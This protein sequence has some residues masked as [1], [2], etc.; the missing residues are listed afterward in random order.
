MSTTPL[1]PHGQSD[2]SQAPAAGLDGAEA[3]AARASRQALVVPPPK[4]PVPLAIVAL[5][6]AAAGFA[7]VFFLGIGRVK[8]P[9]TPAEIAIFEAEPI[10]LARPDVQ[11]A[12]YDAGPAAEG[13]AAGRFANRPL[14]RFSSPDLPPLS[15]EPVGPL[16]LESASDVSP[17][18]A[19]PVE[20]RSAA[21][22]APETLI[23]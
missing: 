7:A 12:S 5:A 22:S 23:L 9:Q 8:T 11:P 3:P 6:A 21:R 18:E 14:S 16:D 10:E 17:P 13:P 20:N 1:D 15:L 19:P 4:P 2:H